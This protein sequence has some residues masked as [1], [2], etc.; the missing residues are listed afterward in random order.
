MKKFTF[1]MLISAFTFLSSEAQS[2]QEKIDK[3]AKDPKTAENA[4]KAD[5]YVSK[6]RAIFDSTSSVA[7]SATSEVKK[8]RKKKRSCGKKNKSK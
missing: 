6:N 2:V 8:E 3:Q 1:L 4:A 5:V 7:S